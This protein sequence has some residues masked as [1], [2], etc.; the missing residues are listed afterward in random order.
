MPFLI[1]TLFKALPLPGEK[2]NKYWALGIGH[3]A[4]VIPL[5]S[6][7]LLIPSFS[8]PYTPCP[9]PNAPFPKQYFRQQIALLT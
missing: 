4:L 6:L 2:V 8:M 3:W 7:V 1:V 9:I 5:V